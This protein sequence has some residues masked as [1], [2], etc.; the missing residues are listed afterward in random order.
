M[1]L[2]ALFLLVLA[3]ST[4]PAGIRA[5]SAAGDEKFVPTER[6]RADAAVAFPVDI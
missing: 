6:I 2:L 1:K 5:E 4:S 3:V